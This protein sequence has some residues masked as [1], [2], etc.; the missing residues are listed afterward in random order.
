MLN[1]EP[2]HFA[3]WNEPID[4]LYACHSRVKNFCHQL[5]I[6]PDYIDQ[7]GCNQAVHNDVKQILTY[8]NQ[9][10]P[11]HHA[12]EEEDF[13]PAL[14]AK[15]PEAQ[16]EVDKLEAQHITLHQTWDE[17]AISLEKLLLGEMTNVDRDL[18]ARFIAGYDQHIAIEEPLFELGRQHLPESELAKMGKIM[19]E[20]RQVECNI[21]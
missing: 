12:D 1:L 15:L 8:F 6:L 16:A 21:S 17:L 14:V 5:S 11:L 13:F 20:R 10:A 7:H 18:I 19:S 3:T 2:Q 9:S 4:M